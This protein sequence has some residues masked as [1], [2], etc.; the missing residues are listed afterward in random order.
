MQ[1]EGV[2]CGIV[3]P[4]RAR[5][6]RAEIARGKAVLNV[7]IATQGPLPFDRIASCKFNSTSP[8]TNW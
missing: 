4:C 1:G 5:S 2:K 8:V 7:Q 3:S 6:D